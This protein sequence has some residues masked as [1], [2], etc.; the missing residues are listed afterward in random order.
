MIALNNLGKL[1]RAAWRLDEAAA[2][3]QTA[4][5]QQ[6]S[7]AK[8][9]NN[10]GNVFADRL[11]FEDAVC[12][13]RRALM[14][15]PSFV[16]ARHN[17]GIALAELGQFCEASA[18][19]SQAAAE[20]PQDAGL[21]IRTALLL[22]V[23]PE[24]VEAI[25]TI[26]SALDRQLDRLLAEDLLIRDPILEAPGP[27]FYLAYHGRN[28]VHLQKK[29]A[30]LFQRAIPSLNFTAH[31]CEA[32]RQR[33]GG[34]IRVG[35]VSRFFH[36][37]SVGDHYAKLFGAFPRGG[38]RYIACSFPGPKDEVSREIETSADEVVSLSSELAEARRQIA[39]SE[40]DAI[41][42]TDIGM[43]SRTYFLAFA[44]LAPV[45][46]VMGGHPVTTGIPMIDYFL[47]SEW[48]ELPEADAH[49]S[50][51]LVRMKNVPHY[52]ARPQL[53][54]EKVRADFPLPPEARWYVCQQALFKIHPEFDAILGEI[55]RRD[56]A[57]IVVLFEGVQPRW[58]FLLIDRFRRSIPDV[59]DR[60]IFLPRLAYH[61]FLAFLP[62]AD[63]L[64]DTIHFTGGTTTM[65]ALGLGLPLITLPDEFHRGRGTYSAIE[66]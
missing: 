20:R 58:K 36:G 45:Q 3:Y 41:L 54:V 23:I 5:A 61:D 64:L 9:H 28:D 60:V 46:C 27:A 26:R 42:Y 38:A 11:A 13:Y 55:L 14:L 63:A 29:I 34:P 66:G 18:E 19:L 35:I 21:K 52:F 40:L 62:L 59:A 44:R 47:S 17:L 25:D 10:L 16:D 56:S 39:A 12:C 6:P 7:F 37:H 50:E 30:A 65:Q 8:A 57:G 43:D 51:R 24:S 1:L 31:H 4:I 2:C 53:R 22:P 32:A 15:D 33:R 48:H 49:Y